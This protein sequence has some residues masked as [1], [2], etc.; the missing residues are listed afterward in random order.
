MPAAEYGILLSKT[1]SWPH[2]I[3]ISLLVKRSEFSLAALSQE[4]DT[5]V[6]SLATYPAAAATPWTAQKAEEEIICR[7]SS[8][9]NRDIEIGRI[10]VLIIRIKYNSCIL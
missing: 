9:A 1:I 3:H 6:V 8:T 4:P 10:A 2:H 7:L 5:S